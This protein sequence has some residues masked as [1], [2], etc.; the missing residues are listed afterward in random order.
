MAWGVDANA[1]CPNAGTNDRRDW[2]LN[3]GTPEL[4]IGDG[5]FT[6]VC[7]DTG[8][9]T[10]SWYD[11]LRAQVGQI[12]YFPVNDPAKMILS[13]S[14]QEKYAIIGFTALRI[15]RVLQGNDPEAVGTPGQS[16]SCSASVSMSPGTTVYLNALSGGGCP[17][18][19]AADTISGL[20]LWKKV[21]NRTTIYRPGV[22]YEYDATAHVVTWRTGNQT[23]V[24]VQ[25][26]WSQ[27]GTPGACGERPNDPNGVCLVASW[28]GVQ[29]GGTRPGGGQDFG[30]RAIRLS[31]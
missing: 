3:I 27:A 22:D 19:I 17:G 7:A 30:V 5:G 4:A 31:E 28:Q 21:R 6:Y 13:P 1:S 25:F 9:S 11:A 24:N 23:G 10:S 20:T 8:H 16:G 26:D 15:E 2:I 14:G 29:V 12:K 18:G